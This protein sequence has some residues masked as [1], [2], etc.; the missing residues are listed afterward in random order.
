MR[1]RAA[2]VGAVSLLILLLAGMTGPAAIPTIDKPL[3]LSDYAHARELARR[4]GK[5]LFVVFRC[6]H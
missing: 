6:Q 5:P 2:Q 4:A 1:N 3:W